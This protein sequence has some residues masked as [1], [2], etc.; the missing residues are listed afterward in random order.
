[1]IRLDLGDMEYHRLFPV[2]I[3]VPGIIGGLLITKEL[4][5]VFVSICVIIYIQKGG[6][7]NPFVCYHPPVRYSYIGGYKG[8]T[9][10]GTSR[11]GPTLP[12]PCPLPAGRIAI[13]VLL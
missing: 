6:A 1:M 13:P 4:G 8:E 3:G 7:R 2:R 9:D 11:S 12:L 5:C 10:N